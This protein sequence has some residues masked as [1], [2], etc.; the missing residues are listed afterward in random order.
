MTCTVTTYKFRN[1]PA[2]GCRY[3]VYVERF[4]TS[5]GVTPVLEWFPTIQE[6]IDAVE[7][8]KADGRFLGISSYVRSDETAN[9]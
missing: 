7:E 3:S 8:M 9:A 4:V 5:A 6:A 1:R 2:R